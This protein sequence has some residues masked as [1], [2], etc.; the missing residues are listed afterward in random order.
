MNWVE[1]GQIRSYPAE[2][3]YDVVIDYYERPEWKSKQFS[4]VYALEIRDRRGSTLLIAEMPFNAKWAVSGKFGQE[5]DTVVITL[6][7]V[8][9]LK[10]G[11]E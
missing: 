10:G 9:V 3:G 6:R 4:G 5:G 7:G 11:M 2:Y 8:L 1:I